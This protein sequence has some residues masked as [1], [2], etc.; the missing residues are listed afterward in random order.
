MNISAEIKGTD[1]EGKEVVLEVSFLNDKK[2]ML[3]ISYQ[4]IE[5]S[6]DDLSE[7]ERLSAYNRGDI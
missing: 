5:L 1:K 4:E 7:I 3:K 2:V 6:T